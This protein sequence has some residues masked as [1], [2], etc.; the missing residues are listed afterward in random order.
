M[1]GKPPVDGDEIYYHEGHRTH[2]GPDIA[3]V[4][5]DEYENPERYKYV[6]EL[7]RALGSEMEKPVGDKGQAYHCKNICE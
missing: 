7:A 4:H 6:Y 1:A 2:H 5:V 3:V